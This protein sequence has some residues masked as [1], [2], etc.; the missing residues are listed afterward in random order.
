MPKV[1]I[2]PAMKGNLFASGW[3]WVKERESQTS[4]LKEMSPERE[5]ED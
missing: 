1:L 4:F 3:D 2:S 5:V